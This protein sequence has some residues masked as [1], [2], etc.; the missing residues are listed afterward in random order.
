MNHGILSRRALTA[1]GAS[2]CAFGL[3]GPEF[4]LWGAPSYVW[5]LRAGLLLVL[6]GLGTALVL[7]ATGRLEASRSAS[8]L[9]AGADDDHGRFHSQAPVDSM[10][11]GS[12]L[13]TGFGGRTGPLV[14]VDGTPMLD[15]VIDV[16][17]KVYGDSGT[18]F[19]HDLAAGMTDG[20]FS[21]DFDTHHT[22][23]F[24]W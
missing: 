18:T 3:F 16:A 1:Y 21:T 14:N 17:G 23:R 4:P 22:D 2:L 6:V 9:A 15:D 12:A 7:S 19:N 8:W 24:G 11:T 10:A 5:A 20:G 13:H